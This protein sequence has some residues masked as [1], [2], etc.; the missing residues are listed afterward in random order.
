MKIGHVL[1][2]I[3]LFVL[4]A[5][6][7]NQCGTIYGKTEQLNSRVIELQ[8][9]IKESRKRE[10]LLLEQIKLNSYQIDVL[11]KHATGE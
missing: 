3:F 10:D 11:T 2:A 8:D 6:I 9:Q 7:A 5:V 4:I 1:Y